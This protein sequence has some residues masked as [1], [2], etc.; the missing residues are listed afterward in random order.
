M[1][2]R[3][4]YIYILTNI[5]NTVNYIGVTNDLLR[6]VAEHR[7]GLVKGF[8]HQ[9]QIKKLVYYETCDTAE[10]AIAREKQLKNWHREWKYNLVQSVNP[11]FED[12]FD[13]LQGIPKRVRDDERKVQ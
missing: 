7:E 9:Y 12:L 2:L 11:A 5:H 1:Q 4:Y 3:T 13:S 8:T 6:R 10:Q